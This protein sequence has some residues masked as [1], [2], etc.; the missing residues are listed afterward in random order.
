MTVLTSK[1]VQ[2]HG[3]SEESPAE[4]LIT[5]TN[6]SSFELIVEFYS[7]LERLIRPD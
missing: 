4:Q 1:R 2:V 3:S 7:K 6:I 5:G